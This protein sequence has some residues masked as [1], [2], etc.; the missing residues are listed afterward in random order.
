M[1]TITRVSIWCLFLS[2]IY[3]YF[4]KRAY[5]VSEVVL[6]LEIYLLKS[7]PPK[8]EVLAK[9]EKRNFLNK[10]LKIM[11]LKIDLY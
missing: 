4:K 5:F 11:F 2:L 8:K 10:L 3:A 1:N 7:G 6:V 9:H